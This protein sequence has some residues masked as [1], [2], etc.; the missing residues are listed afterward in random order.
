ML[1]NPKKFIDPFTVSCLV[2]EKGEINSKRSKV[3][4]R[5]RICS[6]WSPELRNTV[7]SFETKYSIIYMRTIFTLKMAASDSS[8]TIVTTWQTKG[9]I[10][11]KITI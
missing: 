9:V 5:M 1:K 7:L 10:T 11:Q 8:E 4:I 3:F 6:L 2:K